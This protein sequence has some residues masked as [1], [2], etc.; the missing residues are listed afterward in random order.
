MCWIGLCLTCTAPGQPVNESCVCESWFC[1]TH[2]SWKAR[3]A[4]EVIQDK[5]LRKATSVLVLQALCVPCPLLFLQAIFT[6]AWWSWQESLSY[7]G[8]ENLYLASDPESSYSLQDW[9]AGKTLVSS[10]STYCIS[11]LW[12]PEIWA[13]FCGLCPWLEPSALFFVPSHEWCCM[14][15][16]WSLSFY[17]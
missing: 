16:D 9:A 5:G 13:L 1:P 12:K 8:D 10:Q 2:S 4:A 6:K 17:K 15:V 14:G 3:A 11:S 7:P